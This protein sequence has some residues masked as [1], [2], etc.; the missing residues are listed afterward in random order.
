MKS[1][2]MIIKFIIILVGILLIILGL[3]LSFATVLYSGKEQDRSGYY[4][5][6]ISLPII[7]FGIIILRN[8][9]MRNQNLTK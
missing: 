1:K 2:K 6:I 3:F 5:L 8:G 9:I 4:C 7:I